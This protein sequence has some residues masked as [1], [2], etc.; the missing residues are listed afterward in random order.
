MGRNPAAALAPRTRWRRGA[1]GRAGRRAGGRSKRPGLPP[2]GDRRHGP[3]AA[4]GVARGAARPSRGRPRSGAPWPRE[5][6]RPT[7]AMSA[8]PCSRSGIRTRRRGREHA[9]LP[10]AERVGDVLLAGF[11]AGRSRAAA[12][13]ARRRGRGTRRCRRRPARAGLPRA[14]RTASRRDA[15]V[16]R[17]HVASAVESRVFR[18]ASSR[19]TVPA[20]ASPVP[21]GVHEEEPCAARQL[22]APDRREQAELAVV[23]VRCRTSSAAAAQRRSSERQA[24]FEPLAG[25]RDVAGD[26]EPCPPWRARAPRPPG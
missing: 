21:V 6:G 1:G 12:A 23:A 11:A 25:R 19:V 2:Q 14:R 5:G 26:R 4:R 22:D 13:C 3:R 16:S 17:I 8:S 18:T 9:H 20:H 7:C 15:G 10:D 24:G